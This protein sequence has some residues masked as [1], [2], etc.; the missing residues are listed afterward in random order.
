M[1]DQKPAIDFDLRQLEIFREVVD[2]KSFSRAA[3]AVHLVQAS[4]S[5]RIA[6]LETLV[7][8]RLLDRLGRTVVPTRAG[9]ILYKHAIL[10]LEMKRTACLEMA[11]FLGLQQ[12]E[13]MI[14]GS[15]VPGEYILPGLIGRFGKKYPAISVSLTISDSSNVEQH[16]LDGTFEIGVVGSRG[17]D[18]RLI[19]R[20]LWKDELVLAV[21]ADH[22][23]AGKATVPVEALYEEP[24][25]LREKGSGTLRMFN[26]YLQEAGSEGIDQLKQVTRLSTSTAVKEGIKTG[27]G[28][29]V[30]SSRAVETEMACGI[31]KVLRIEE[32]PMVRSFYLIRDRRRIASPICQTMIDFL[33]ASATEESTSG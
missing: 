28:V 10:L 8:T 21:P 18:G 15:T 7:G 17:S 11:G 9:E 14:G 4:V 1:P 31:L 6:T 19:I 2:L 22:P 12:G 24:F 30:L 25:I 20:E 33:R 5:E 23:W 26:H 16:V 13:L 27:V 32:L 3:E 29:S